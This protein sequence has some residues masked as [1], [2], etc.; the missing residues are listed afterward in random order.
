M[1]LKVK[2]KDRECFD[3]T[4]KFQQ[5]ADSPADENI[6]TADQNGTRIEA[7][8]ILKWSIIHFLHA[9]A[10]GLKAYLLYHSWG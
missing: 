3:A 9:K 1:L 4:L 8:C 2:K 6:R 10:K 7:R 5:L